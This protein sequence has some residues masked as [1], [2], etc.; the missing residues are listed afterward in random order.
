M[1]VGGGAAVVGATTAV[2]DPSPVGMAPYPPPV[3]IVAVVGVTAA[4]EE[5]SPVGTASY[6][7][8]VDVVTREEAGP[9]PVEAPL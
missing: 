6:P 3:D 1:P 7:P 5:A 2:E 9:L 4:V 8:L